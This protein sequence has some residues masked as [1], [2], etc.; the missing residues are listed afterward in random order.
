MT[1]RPENVSWVGFTPEQTELLD[2]LD[3]VGNNGWSRN[4][5][6]DELMPRLLADCERAELTLHR[7]KEAMA[8]VGYGREALHQLD[9]W[10]S[11]RTTGRFGR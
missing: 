9:R 1:R 5:Q 10:E 11:K 3:H 7:I 6:T 8:S 4:S 2:F